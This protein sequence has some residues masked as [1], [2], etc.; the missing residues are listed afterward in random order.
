M[1]ELF[2]K[3]KKHLDKLEVRTGDFW[4]MFGIALA[5]IGLWVDSVGLVC[6]ALLPV[7]V[8]GHSFGLW[9]EPWSEPYEEEDEDEND[10]FGLVA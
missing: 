10:G 5:V 1:K 9:T 4:I 2:L 3:I 7:F 6:L 8:A